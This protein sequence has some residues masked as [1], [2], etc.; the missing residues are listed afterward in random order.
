MIKNAAAVEL[1]RRGGLA[2][3]KKLGKEHYVKIGKK[4]KRKQINEKKKSHTS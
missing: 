4:G 3:K 2:T 1:G